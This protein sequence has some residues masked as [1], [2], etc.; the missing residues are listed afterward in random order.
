MIPNHKYCVCVTNIHKH[1]N[2]PKKPLIHITDS[3]ERLQWVRTVKG[4][5]FINTDSQERCI[6]LAFLVADMAKVDIIEMIT[7]YCQHIL[8]S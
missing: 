5:E 7:F 2:L 4:Q 1:N 8:C 6:A 3:V